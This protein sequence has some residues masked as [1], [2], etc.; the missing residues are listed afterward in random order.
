MAELAQ[1][2]NKYAKEPVCYGCTEETRKGK[3]WD[4]DMIR[5]CLCDSSWPVGF[6]PGEYQLAQYFGPGCQNSKLWQLP[7]P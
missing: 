6:G 4:H 5:G 2:D 7:R 3:S 1:V